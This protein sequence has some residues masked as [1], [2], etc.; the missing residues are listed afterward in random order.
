MLMMSRFGKTAIFRTVGNAALVL[1]AVLFSLQWIT[2]GWGLLLWSVVLLYATFHEII[3]RA[4][5]YVA[6]TPT[7][8]PGA[9][10]WGNKSFQEHARKTGLAEMP[11]VGV[12]PGKH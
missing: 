8:I 4:L 11:Q 1:V 12:V 10:F 6:V 3:G 9:F 7:T 2:G 5:F